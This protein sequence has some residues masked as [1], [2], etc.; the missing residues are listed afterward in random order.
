MPSSTVQVICEAIYDIQNEN[1]SAMVSC[2]KEK[3]RE[4]AVG[5]DDIDK[6][7]DETFESDYVL[8]LHRTSDGVFRTEHSRSSFFKK[9]FLY[10]SPVEILLGKT[11][12]GMLPF[13]TFQL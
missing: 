12:T 13:I 10:V 6:L 11:R 3:L 7:I 4:K 9:E 2:L 8:A 5:S 1:A